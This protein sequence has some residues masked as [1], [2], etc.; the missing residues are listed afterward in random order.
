MSP[1]SPYGTMSD[2]DIDEHYRMGW[3]A[4]MNSEPLEE[5]YP[6]A[7]C[8]GWLAAQKSNYLLQRAKHEPKE[9]TTSRD[10]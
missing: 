2:N 6:Y 3:I 8:E 4:Y 9:T 1:H 7:W 10:Y 5:T